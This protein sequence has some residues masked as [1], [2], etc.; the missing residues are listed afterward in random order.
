MVY[1]ILVDY[2]DPTVLIGGLHSHLPLA[3]KVACK[4]QGY[5]RTIREV[6]QIRRSIMMLQPGQQ[7]IPVTFGQ[8][9]SRQSHQLGLQ[10]R[11]NSCP[12]IWS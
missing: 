1:V 5:I 10:F 9:R 7:F 8:L 3:V 4:I 11:Q 12:I 2:Y 6:D